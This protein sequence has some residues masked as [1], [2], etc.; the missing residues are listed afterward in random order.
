MSMTIAQGFTQGLKVSYVDAHNNPAVPPA[1]AGTL[2]W[3][4]DDPAIVE[5]E[6]AASGN[7]VSVTA[8]GA[9]GTSTTISVTD[10]VF[11]ASLSIEVVAGPAA[12]LLIQSV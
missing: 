11:T 5:L 6:G 10:G 12:G 1:S 9:A 4:T 2:L 3:K 8:K 7:T